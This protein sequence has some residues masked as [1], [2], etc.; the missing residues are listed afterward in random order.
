MD[1]SKRV[2]A[3][4][5]VCLVGGS[6]AV[7]V[8]YLVTPVSGSLTV[9][10]LLDKV[11]AH[12]DAMR[13]ALILDVP[14]TLVIPAVLFVGGLAGARTSWLASIG[15]ALCLV[16]G[17]GGMVLIAQDALL[18]EAAAQPDRAAAVSLVTGYQDNGMVAGLTIGYLTAHAVGFVLLGVALWRATAT[19]VWAAVAVAVWPLLEMAGYASDLRVVAAVGYG[20]LVI[21]YGACAAGLIR[22]HREADLERPAGAVRA[23]QEWAS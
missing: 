20:L 5:V 21:G 4:G 15:V 22:A 6:V 18:Y 23:A 9:A 8:Q 1:S 7:F 14:L 11:S 17:L 16:P 10:E 19:P 2:T 13:L 3:A 12:T